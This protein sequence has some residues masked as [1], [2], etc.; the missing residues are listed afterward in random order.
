MLMMDSVVE[1]P[2]WVGLA[3]GVLVLVAGS[4]TLTR[5]CAVLRSVRI[6]GRRIGEAVGLLVDGHLA[7]G[8]A[9]VGMRG[10]PQLLSMV[11]RGIR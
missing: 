3:A 4:V 6:D 11:C 2:A 9:G 1:G 8:L 5:Q 10:L 7:D